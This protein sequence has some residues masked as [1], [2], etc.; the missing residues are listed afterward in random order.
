VRAELHVGDDLPPRYRKGIFKKP[1]SYPAWVC[2]DA[3]GARA[4]PDIEALGGLNMSVKLMQVPG[5]KL[6]DDEKHTQDLLGNSAPTSLA[7]TVVDRARL[8][9]Q[10]REQT[11]LHYFLDP[12]RPRIFELLVHALYGQPVASPLECRYHSGAP[13]LIGQGQAMQYSMRP[14]AVTC[15]PM[16]SL[17]ANLPARSLRDTMVDT[18]ARGEVLFDLLIQVQTDPRAMPIENA[19]VRWPERLSPWLMAGTL[20]IFQQRFD[21]PAQRQF[22]RELRFTPWHAVPEHR[23]LGSLNRARRLLYEEC[24]KASPLGPQHPHVHREPTGD[25]RLEEPRL[26]RRHSLRCAASEPPQA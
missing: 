10:R 5:L 1:R 8:E 25:E 21:T 23:P 22:A 24:F 3:P 26:N 12:R 2:F 11:P 6:L 16:P 17:P 9:Q 13:F 19:A 20:R 4:T 15:S 7:G 18:L 14:R